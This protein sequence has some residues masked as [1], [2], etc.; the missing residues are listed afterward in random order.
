MT[1]AMPRSRIS[2]S[3]SKTRSIA[4]G[5]SPAG[6]PARNRTP[7]PRAAPPRD[8]D[9]LA[10][11]AG[12]RSR[13]LTAALGQQRKELEHP[14]DLPGALATRQHER[15]DVEVLRDGE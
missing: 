8:R 15:R 6:G 7:R 12:Q 11:P 2:T 9:Q 3:F 5:D 10:L 4:T 14:S 13:A 1:T